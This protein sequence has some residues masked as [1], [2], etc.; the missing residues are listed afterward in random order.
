M[1]VLEA[2]PESGGG[3]A[4]GYTW[5]QQVYQNPTVDEV[6]QI[7]AA[8]K[9]HGKTYDFKIHPGAG[10]GFNCDARASYNQA[11]AEDAWARTL[12]WFRQHLG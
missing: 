11:A 7:E 12:G 2:W 6:G 1:G 10:H 8:L 9:Q 4:S 3:C 5:G